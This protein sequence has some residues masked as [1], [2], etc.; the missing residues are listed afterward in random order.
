MSRP[1]YL[2]VYHSRP[3]PAHWAIWIPHK[4]E[5]S[6]EGMGK[7]IQ[8]EGNPSE[9]FSHEFKRNYD[10]SQDSR[11]HSV[12][13]LGTIDGSNILDSDTHANGKGTTDV[14]AIDEVEKVALS[15]PAPRPSLRRRFGPVSI[16]SISSI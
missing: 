15:V 16:S 3:F 2:I 10:S 12:I 1:I 4:N 8:V 5:P 7:V 13:L 11:L 14:T 9:G 6:P